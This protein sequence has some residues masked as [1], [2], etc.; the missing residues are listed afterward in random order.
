MN[1]KLLFL[2]PVKNKTTENYC[3]K[4][5]QLEFHVVLG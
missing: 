5:Y 2:I 4:V 1:R 3:M